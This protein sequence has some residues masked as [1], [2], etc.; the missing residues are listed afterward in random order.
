M[1]QHRVTLRPPDLLV[2]NADFEFEIRRN[3][4]KFG[5]L[6]VSKGGVVFMPKFKY[7]KKFSRKRIGWTELLE[8]A[9]QR[10]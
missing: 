8:F 10:K 9:K 3:G 2:G 1:A 5:R 4:Q 6:W 7:G